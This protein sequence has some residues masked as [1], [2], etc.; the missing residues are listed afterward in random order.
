[1]LPALYDDQR[2]VVARLAGMLI[3]GASAVLAM[4]VQDSSVA[5]A[6]EAAPARVRALPALPGR[7]TFPAFTIARDPFARR[8]QMALARSA[9]TAVAGFAVRAIIM[10]ARARALVD[11][12]GNVE[13]LAVGDGLGD[14]TITGIDARGVQLSDGTR[15][16]LEGAK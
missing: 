8:G 3:L 7:L 14:L 6:Q 1:M 4:T 13:V 12:G 9:S 2:R 11:F 15:L 5:I 10:G 16:P